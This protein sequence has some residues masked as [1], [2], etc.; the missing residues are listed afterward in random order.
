MKA[1]LITVKSSIETVQRTVH[2][3]IL[4]PKRPLQSATSHTTRD[5]TPAL[6]VYYSFFAAWPLL[7]LLLL[8]PFPLLFPF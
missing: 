7:L 8:L 1:A 6:D 5:F 3:E 2:A 4:K